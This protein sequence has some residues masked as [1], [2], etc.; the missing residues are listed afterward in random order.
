[1]APPQ[2]DTEGYRALARDLA[3]RYGLDPDIFERQIQQ[4]SGFNPTAVS[5]MG[6]SG[7]AQFMPSHWNQGQFDPFDPQVAL[8]RA[9]QLMSSHVENYG[10][11]IA[12]ALAAYNAGRGNL[13]EFG[14]DLSAMLNYRRPNTGVQPFAETQRYLERILG[15]SPMTMNY[16]PNQAPPTTG[17]GNSGNI[18]A[19]LLALQNR[20]SGAGG[21]AGITPRNI[22]PGATIGGMSTFDPE[23]LLARSISLGGGNPFS[24]D[25]VIRGILGQAAMYANLS[26][27]LGGGGMEELL[28]TGGIQNA[29]S[30]GALNDLLNQALSQSGRGLDTGGAATGRTAPGRLGAAEQAMFNGAMQE[31][32]TPDQARGAMVG[33]AGGGGSP[34]DA[35]M[36]AAMTQAGGPGGLMNYLLSSSPALLDE[37]MALT[38]W[39]NAGR[40]RALPAY[41]ENVIRP[42]WRAFRPELS[43]D[44]SKGNAYPS[45]L[46]F[47][48]DMMT[49]SGEP[50]MIRGYEKGR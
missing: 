40:T 29:F 18:L 34:L 35:Q 30:T 15:G 7:I 44:I 21:A 28:N 45:V 37:I 49:R 12:K 5:P 14:N 31:G 17:P 1:M 25:P 48:M 6:A 26:S 8:E 36:Q 13:A 39:G 20:A 33:S 10:G 43:Q 41:S 47:I 42:Y 46:Q 2:N 9:A 24:G 4:E 23:G 50:G 3:S 11:D 16:T 27:L 32:L 19:E 22:L 38:S